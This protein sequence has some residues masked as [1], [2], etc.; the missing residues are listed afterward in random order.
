MLVL[1]PEIKDNKKEGETGFG[2][3]LNSKFSL[4]EILLFWLVSHPVPGVHTILEIEDKME[5]EYPELLSRVSG[6]EAL[7]GEAPALFWSLTPPPGQRIFLFDLDF[8]EHFFPGSVWRHPAIEAGKFM[9]TLSQ[10]SN[11][12]LTETYWKLSMHSI[13]SEQL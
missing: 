2:I 8:L 3:K 12:K 6:Y 13:F 10:S 1:K 9:L 11:A 7:V 4:P 5:E